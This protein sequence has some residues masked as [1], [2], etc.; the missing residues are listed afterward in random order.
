VADLSRVEL[1]VP[2]H[3]EERRLEPSIRRLV[4]FLRAGFPFP[5]RITI[6]DNASTDRTQEI[7]AKLADELPEVSVLRLAE[8]GRGR[9]LSTAWSRSDADVLAY[10][11]VDL[12]TDLAALL[13]LVAPLVSGHSDLAIGT[14]L[15][16]SARVVRGP[17]REVLSR[18]Y[19]ALLRA[20]LA[21]G[22]SDAQCGFK[23]IRSDC[24]RVLLPFVEDTGW[25][26]DTELLVLAERCGLR[27]TE[28]PVDWVDDLD[29]R[30]QLTST[31]LGDLRGV[32]RLGRALLSGALPIDELRR[33]LGTDDGRPERR[34]GLGAQLMRF[35]GI[36]VV[37]TAAYVVLYV[38]FRAAM[39][40]LVANAVALL[41]TA[42]ANT[43]ANR[44][45]TFAG[46]STAPWRYRVQSAAVFV[47]ALAVTSVA[48]LLLQAGDANAGRGAEVLVLLSANLVAAVLRFT[49]LR[50][51]V[52]RSS[53][54]QSPTRPARRDGRPAEMAGSSS[55]GAT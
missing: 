55:G 12:S 48:L 23:A 11:D 18:G 39:P 47:V 36:G 27:I 6:A 25:F 49:L 52:F 14:R 34:G 5:T 41:L 3:D 31:V 33:R 53:R 45:W 1:V 42:V 43:T 50:G 19:N 10:T 38:A 15:Q 54:F 46:R 16:P 37:S 51:W 20:T 44:R 9:A 7:A 28:V 26:F 13:P 8:K 4:E 29:S 24:A 40:A 21:A 22:F 17:K 2:V 30:V 32:S 35:A